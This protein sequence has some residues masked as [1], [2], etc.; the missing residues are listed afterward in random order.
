LAKVRRPRLWAE[1]ALLVVAYG[2]YA[3]IRDLRGDDTSATAFARAAANGVHIVR[4]ERAIGVY[5]ELAVQ[6]LALHVHLLVRAFDVFYATAHVL[7]TAAVLIW[8]F[9]AHPTRYRRMRWALLLATA[10]ALVVFWLLPTAPPR[11]LPNG[12]FTDT[13]FR[14]GGLWSFRTPAIEHII[15]PFAAMPSLHAAWATLCALA[16]LPSCRRAW[17]RGLAV[18]YPLLVAVV[19][20]VTG[21]HYFAD[22]LAGTVIALMAWSLTRPQ[23]WRRMRSGRAEGSTRHR[24][25]ALSNHGRSLS[26]AG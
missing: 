11:M 1:L 5:Q 20:V 19:V 21:N 9:V 23:R 6:R 10:A 15:D 18:G 8:I 2:L 7:V 25:S 13:L 24:S 22:V 26:R 16:I 4:L 17:S 3:R 12:G 14:V